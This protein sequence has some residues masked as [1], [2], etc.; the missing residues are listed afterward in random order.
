MVPKALLPPCCPLPEPDFVTFMSLTC[1]QAPSWAFCVFIPALGS[2]LPAVIPVPAGV[3]ALS[4]VVP[5]LDVLLQQLP[6]EMPGHGK[7]QPMPLGLSELGL[8]SGWL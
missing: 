8:F 2:F 1:L 6:N 4:Y 3:S 5:A 7:S